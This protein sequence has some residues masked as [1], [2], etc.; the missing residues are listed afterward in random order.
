MQFPKLSNILSEIGFTSRNTV[1]VTITSLKKQ[2]LIKTIGTRKNYFYYLTAA[3]INYIR[4]LEDF[5]DRMLLLQL[6]KLQS[7]GD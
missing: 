6:A 7:Y 2:G 5:D 3:G 1:E 4:N